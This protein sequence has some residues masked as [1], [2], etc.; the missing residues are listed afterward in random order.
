MKG[1]GD[2]LKNTRLLREC[3]VL[4]GNCIEDRKLISRFLV[5]FHVKFVNRATGLAVKNKVAI[6]KPLPQ[7]P[8]DLYCYLP[9]LNVCTVISFVDDSV[10][11]SVKDSAS[12][13]LPLSCSA[14]GILNHCVHNREVVLIHDV[15]RRLKSVAG[16][17][18]EIA[19]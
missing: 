16:P 2:R 7:L 8:L 1:L 10:V 4:L 3:G 18:V 9:G 14:V 11:V 17:S 6:R 13:S 19:G 5:S 12:V 15:K